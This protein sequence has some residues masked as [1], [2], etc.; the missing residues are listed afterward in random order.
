MH[1]ACALDLT[2]RYEQQKADAD[3]TLR[4]TGPR[5]QLYESD[6]QPQ[7]H[8]QQQHQG[9]LLSA[10]G[11][12]ATQL[13]AASAAVLRLPSADRLAVEA[14]EAA[15]A[16]A[17]SSL[18]APPL[19]LPL[20]IGNPRARPLAASTS[21]SSSSLRRRH[22]D[23]RSGASGPALPS[24]GVGAGAGAGAGASA[25]AGVGLA[26]R[27][28]AAFNSSDDGGGG[29]GGGSLGRPQRTSQF[30]PSFLQK[31]HK[32]TPPARRS[33]TQQRQPKPGHEATPPPA[34]G[35]GVGGGGGDKPLTVQELTESPPATGTAF[36]ATAATAAVAPL[37]RGKA[38]AA[39]PVDDDIAAEAALAAPTEEDAVAVSQPR[40]ATSSDENLD[41]AASAVAP[42]S[43]RQK[44]EL[45]HKR[46]PD[47]SALQEDTA[48][49]PIGKREPF[50]EKQEQDEQQPVP[51]GKTNAAG[52]DALQVC[53]L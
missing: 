43:P 24:M 42:A 33:R 50:G 5:R 19:P 28:P 25:G 38:A 35:V 6:N 39:V 1:H 12:V 32:S 40:H 47:S 46:G 14:A 15:R 36:T 3:A 16:A 9:G 13:R 45:E 49:E 2:R 41:D 18:A 52:A 22:N 30:A 4:L 20:Q 48:D 7:Q 11:P 51:D 44:P 23:D 37:N 53:C 29:G 34:A 17:S 27:R 21:S 8:H 26:S 10:T 31:H